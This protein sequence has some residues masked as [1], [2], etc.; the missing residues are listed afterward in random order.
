VYKA[1]WSCGN[2][3]T[4]T[5]TFF[6]DEWTRSKVVEK[7]LEALKNK[8]AATRSEGHHNRWVV[9]GVTKEDMIIKTIID[10]K[11]SGKAEIISPYPDLE[12]KL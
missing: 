9:T 12:S 3:N 11:K 5:S 6:P 4:K 10:V 8:R 2:S 7:I 1:K